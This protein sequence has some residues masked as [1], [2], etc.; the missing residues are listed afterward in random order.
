MTNLITLLTQKTPLKKE[1]IANILK[2]LDE[3]STIPFIARYRKEMTGGADDEVLREFE[4]IYISSKKILE[5]K[6]EVARLISERA[7][8]TDSIKKSIEEADTLRVLED[9]YRPFKE[10]KSSRATTAMANGLTPLANTLQS[11][12]LT[13]SEFKQ[14]AKKFIKGV[15]SSVDGAVKGAQDI[16]A[17][18][19]A[20]LPREREAIR[21][22]MLRFG[23]LEVKKSKSFDENG[24]FKNFANKDA[25]GEKVAYIPSHRYLAIM[26]GVKEKELS[27]KITTDI[28]H[29]EENI[30][31]YKIPSH[32]S[33]SKEL[34]FE[35][36]R[37]GLKRLLLPSLERELHVELKEKADI[38]AINTFGKNLSQLLMT[39]PVTKRVLLGVD[40]AFVSGCKLAVID[41]NG[42]YLESAVIYPTEPKKDYENSKNK[43]LTLTK[44]Y[45]ITG[46][47]IGNGTASRETQEFFARLNKEED[48]KLNYTVV[49]E[50]GA[51]VY[52]AS[53]IA[54]QEYPNLDVTIRGA[55]SIAGRLQ[56]PMAALVKI[57]PKSLGIGQYQHDVDQ[58][59]LEKKLTDVTQDLVNRVG[60]DINSASASL[61][62]YVAGVGAKVAQNI[63]AFREEN[64]LFK[65]KEQL[66]KV[67]GLGKKAYEQAAGFVRIKNGK[68][69]FDNSGIHPESYD[70]AKKLSALEL[71][72][73]DIKTKSQELHVGEE[74]LKDIIKELNKPGFDPREDLPPIPFKDGV[75]DIAM[76][77]VGS[78]VSGV[79]RNIAD[80]GAF[81][82]I[83]LK[84]DGM[85]HISKMSE[86]RISHPLEILALNQY[87]PQIEVISI[88]SEKGKIGLSLV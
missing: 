13:T 24:T 22:N 62:A 5:R 34:L 36:Y 17:E 59:L 70:I 50:A 28:S 78:F 9:I 26:R 38:S 72:S 25:K 81:V 10:K 16:L 83:G 49:S 71:S 77:S 40:P 44:K 19:Y 1:H 48:A 33:S 58:K 65:T 39:P 61:L 32:A 23:I 4:T 21:N 88:D 80:F 60:V 63:I 35:A 55:I 57:D 76:L 45:N 15:V 82:D 3:G 31:R 51:S 87:L 56:D 46:V 75:T 2:L 68:S 86:K 18:R 30:K 53:K 12:R 69:V 7:T 66:L 27:V 64:G 11:A 41:E 14:E 47:A 8:L 20:D 42:N 85:I 67:K 79:V 29:I 84:N 43:V 52:S 37:D 73:I 74:T 6:E 54:A